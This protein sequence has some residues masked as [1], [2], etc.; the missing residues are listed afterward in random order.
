MSIPQI[1]QTPK[2]KLTLDWQALNHMTNPRV[3]M[4]VVLHCTASQP[5]ATVKGVLDYWHS[6]RAW[7]RPG[8]HYLITADGVIHGLYPENKATYGVRG[9]NE[10]AIHVCYMGGIDGN[11]KGADTRTD[12]QRVAQ[13]E[14]VKHLLTAYPGAKLSGHYAHANKACPSFDVP[15][16][17]AANGIDAVRVRVHPKAPV[18][19]I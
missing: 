17:A 16:W 5:T 19:S 4:H 10:N 1:A 3:I 13:I 11:G 14:M 6:Q 12:A 9:L 18:A 7:D 15:G 2:H 8:Y